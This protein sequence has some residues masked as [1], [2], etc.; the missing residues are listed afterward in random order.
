MTMSAF[1]SGNEVKVLAIRSAA[2]FAAAKDAKL[3][4]EAIA[5]ANRT[6]CS[7]QTLT[8]AARDLDENNPEF[9]IEARMA[10]LHWLVEGYGYEITGLDVVNA[11]SHTMKAAEIAGR[12][13][14]TRRR[15]HDLVAK[16]TFGGRFV[17]KV[18]DR[19]LGI[20]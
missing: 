19:Q 2:W 8:R 15:I 5:L 7:P 12:A 13:D 10:A 6:P 4:D 3:F 16:E 17:T 11:Y 14:E 18:L 20:S 9:A 1:A